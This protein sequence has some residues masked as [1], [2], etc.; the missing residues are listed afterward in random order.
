MRTLSRWILDIE[1]LLIHSNLLSLS[2]VIDV[3]KTKVNRTEK[4]F[5]EAKSRFNRS[6]PSLRGE[7]IARLTELLTEQNN[8]PDTH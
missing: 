6:S 2:F 7:R 4:G 1:V 3:R 5:Q 8:F